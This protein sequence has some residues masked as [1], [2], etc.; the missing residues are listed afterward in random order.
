MGKTVYN[1]THAIIRERLDI[2]QNLNKFKKIHKNH[3]PLSVLMISIDSVSRL[4]M[5]RA[6]PKT[7]HH[8]HDSGWF[9]MQGYNKVKFTLNHC[10]AKIHLLHL[11]VDRF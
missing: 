3:R 9:E 2:R 11:F 7:F 4:N 1:N 8:L 5:I 6:M 10:Q